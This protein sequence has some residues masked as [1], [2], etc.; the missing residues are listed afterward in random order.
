MK[1]TVLDGLK[2]EK[3][4]ERKTY[5]EQYAEIKKLLNKIDIKAKNFSETSDFYYDELFTIIDY[6]K[7]ADEVLNDKYLGD[8]VLR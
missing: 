3:F 2:M 5:A 4:N 8:S 1:N 6:L 7:N